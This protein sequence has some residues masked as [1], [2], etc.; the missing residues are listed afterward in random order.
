MNFPVPLV[1]GLSDEQVI[2]WQHYYREASDRDRRREEG[3]WR[4]TQTEMNADESGWR[5]PAD[6]RRRIVY[7]DHEYE[8]QNGGSSAD[9]VLKYSFVYYSLTLPGTELAADIERI[10]QALAGGGWRPD[11]Q[12]GEE[13]SWRLG[14]LVC[15]VSTLDR[16]PEDLRAGRTI[17]SS[18][19]ALDVVIRT[20][21]LTSATARLP[22][23]VLAK[24]MRVKDER[25]NPTYVDDLGALVD[26]HPFHVELG[27][28][29]SIEAGVPA[30]NHLHELYRVTDLDTG[31]F[32]FGGPGDDLITR[33]L[34]R[35]STEF[36]ALGRLFK[37]SFVAEPTPAHEALLALQR[38]GYVVGP[39]LTNNFDGLAHRVGLREQ[40][41]RRYDE[42][43][44]DVEFS[45]DARSLLVI[46][47]HADRRRVQARARQRG[48]KVVYLDPEGYEVGGRFIAYPLEGPRTGD[49]I[50]AR[51]ATDGLTGLCG[52]LG[53]RS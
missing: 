21:G 19:R 1:R 6:Q 25:E 40:F 10:A 17:P 43:V 42:E 36:E 11:S 22:W 23:E 15:S 30:L 2:R 31:R 14:D 49:L 35:P 5:G 34:L 51:T 50:C 47:S 18:Y 48:L 26:L 8:F 20:D 44:P 28:G 24:G 41:L 32:I 33:L 4:R 13:K 3:I 27:C 38:A 16:H 37:A 53:L 7:Y 9:L 46:G 29:P 39:I 45:P 12:D 52:R